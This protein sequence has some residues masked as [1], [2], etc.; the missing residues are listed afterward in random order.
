MD[1]IS[2]LASSIAIATAVLQTADKLQQVLSAGQELRD[3]IDEIDKLRSVFEEAQRAFI[4]RKLHA[5]LP[6]V[7]LEAGSRIVSQ[8]QKQLDQLHALL[9]RCLGDRSGRTSKRARLFWLGLRRKVRSIEQSLMSAR[10]SLCSLWGAIELSDNTSIHLSLQ[11]MTFMGQD[12]LSL[13]SQNMEVLRSIA[14]S[15]CSPSDAKPPTM[16]D[17]VFGPS[18]NK[19]RDDDKKSIIERHMKVADHAPAPVIRKRYP[20]Y[21]QNPCEGWCSCQCH[22]PFKMQSPQ[23]LALLLG[24]LLITYSGFNVQPTR[25]TERSCRRQ[26]VPT[27]RVLYRFPAWFI[28]RMIYFAASISGMTGPSITLSMP[29]TVSP[30][31]LVFSYAVQGNMNRI[32]ELFAAGLAS[33]YDVAANNGRTALHVSIALQMALKFFF[34]FFDFAYSQREYSIRQYTTTTN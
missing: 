5:E 32:Q 8:A 17:T 23:S 9:E 11:E 6:R 4:E 1:P 24:N 29:R 12:Q 3:L 14:S 30:N 10:L 16:S 27:V 26:S 2:V 13:L 18:D 33:P 7:A 19:E 15:V 31:A 22:K 25:C 34:F 20:R 28:Q 21:R